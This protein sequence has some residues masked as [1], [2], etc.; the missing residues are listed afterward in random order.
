MNSTLN[1]FL[2]NNEIPFSGSGELLKQKFYQ[3][4]KSFKDSLNK[5]VS[6]KKEQIEK[7]GIITGGYKLIIRNK[8]NNRK[9]RKTK[10]NRKN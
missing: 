5:I 6:I 8:K 4:N 3:R 1:I 7:K 2:Q 9:S 10:K